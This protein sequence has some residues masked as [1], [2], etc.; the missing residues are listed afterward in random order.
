[1]L[2]KTPT[3]KPA[4][5][6]T[7]EYS[8]PSPGGRPRKGVVAAC[9]ALSLIL[10]VGAVML[11]LLASL[12]RNH[13]PNVAYIDINAVEPVPP[14]KAVIHSPAPPPPNAGADRSPPLPEASPDPAGQETAPLPVKSPA[15]EVLATSLGRGMTSGY[16]SSFA[17]GKNLRDDIREYYLTLLEKIN[18]K[19]WL[20]AETLKETAPHDGVVMFAIGRDGGVDDVQLLKGTGSREV[21]LA[22]VEVLKDAA[23]FPP[24]PAGYPLAEFRAPLRIAAPLHLLSVKSS[25]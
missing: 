1:M 18:V 5:P 22:I 19:W 3:V 24:L 23:P 15:A 6:A 9:L 16:F 10:H 7:P 11:V 21:D 8:P 20:K 14:P 17:E 13:A 2:K 25:R 4:E 12:Q